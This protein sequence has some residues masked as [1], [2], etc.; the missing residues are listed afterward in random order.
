MVTGER[1]PNWPAASCNAPDSSVAGLS[2]RARTDHGALLGRVARGSACRGHSPSNAAETHG[3]PTMHGNP[4]SRCHVHSREGQEETD[5]PALLD[6]ELETVDV[7]PA[8]EVDPAVEKGATG[9]DGDGGLGEHRDLEG[10]GMDGRDPL[11]E[12][13]EDGLVGAS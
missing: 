4:G 12:E 2:G 9:T 8:A 6:G 3:G 5:D 11:A 13:N 1:F 7:R 10:L